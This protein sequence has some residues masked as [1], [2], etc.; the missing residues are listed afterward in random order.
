MKKSGPTFFPWAAKWFDM[1]FLPWRN[2]HLDKIN[3]LNLPESI[4][5]GKPVLLVG[6][7]IS[8][9]DGFIFHEIQK[10]VCPSWPIYSVMLE[11]ELKERPIFRLLG[12]VGIDPDSSSSVIHALKDLQALRKKN[13]NF[14]LSYFPQGKIVPSFKR[15][16]DFKSGVDLFARALAPLTIIPVG[17]HIEPMRGFSPTLFASLG[18]PMKIERASSM[19]LILQDLVQN[20]IDRIYALLSRFGEDFPAHLF[21]STRTQASV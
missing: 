4:Q 18:R 8:N 14:F 15:P 7:H 16:L 2:F 11:K 12:G 3:F 13:P 1:A 20:E 5:D 19:H 17:L 10:R 21:A 6:N 9:W